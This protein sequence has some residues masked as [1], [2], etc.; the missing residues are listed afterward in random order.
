V[1]ITAYRDVLVPGRCAFQL[2]LTNRAYK[3][4]CLMKRHLSCDG[5]SAIQLLFSD[6]FPKKTPL[7]NHVFY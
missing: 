7:S 1:L 2:N 3:W 4:T 6:T 5:G